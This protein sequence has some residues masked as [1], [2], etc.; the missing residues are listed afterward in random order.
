MAVLVG[1]DDCMVPSFGM[2]AILG[3]AGMG[4]GMQCCYR[5]DIHSTGHCA[6]LSLL[7]IPRAVAPSFLD[8]TRNEMALGDGVAST[9]L[10]AMAEPF[11]KL[12]MIGFFPVPVQIGC[13]IHM[14]ELGV[15][16]VVNV[17]C[18]G[19]D[20]ADMVARRKQ[21]K[22]LVLAAV[23]VLDASKGVGFH[24]RE[25]VAGLQV[26]EVVVLLQPL[27][28]SEEL[29]ISKAMMAEIAF[30]AVGG[31]RFHPMV[32]EI[33]CCEKLAERSGLISGI[34][35][36]VARSDVMRKVVVGAVG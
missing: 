33:P 15:V 21:G 11:S 19:C 3:V 22:T 32:Y 34:H 12:A 31:F 16:E 20:L 36:L 26:E 5:L 30:D 2:R 13:L 8:Q 14:M 1:L 4:L 27:V 29:R 6:V 35:Q 7:K 28:G 9:V 23:V 24:K 18:G 25:E 10:L 17:S